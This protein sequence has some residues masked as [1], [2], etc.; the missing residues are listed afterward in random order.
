MADNSRRNDFAFSPTEDMWNDYTHSFTYVR[1]WACA[2]VQRFTHTHAQP[3]INSLKLGVRTLQINKH[4]AADCNSK[5]VTQIRSRLHLSI[6]CV[7]DAVSVSVRACV[8][9]EHKCEHVHRSATHSHPFEPIKYKRD[10]RVNTN[11]QLT[12]TTVA[13]CMDIGISILFSGYH[14]YNRELLLLLLQR[15]CR[16]KF[17]GK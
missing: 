9:C 6:E 5:R 3:Q 8:R 14:I 11:T 16:Q 2:R 7:C 13:P 4:L 17:R 15:F 1:M 10:K 12:H